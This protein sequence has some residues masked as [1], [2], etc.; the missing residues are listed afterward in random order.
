MIWLIAYGAGFLVTTGLVY[1]RMLW[2]ERDTYRVDAED[3]ALFLIGAVMIGAVWPLFALAVPVMAWVKRDLEKNHPREV[4]N[5]QRDRE[6]EIRERER[7]IER[8]E[9]ELG[10]REPERAPNFPIKR[11]WSL[12]GRVL[13]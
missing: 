7:E 3:Y 2:N 4:A 6:F 12:V 5:R 1:R 9:I 8:I 13:E 10:I 11:K